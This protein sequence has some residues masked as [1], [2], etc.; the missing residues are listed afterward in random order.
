[1]SRRK[2]PPRRA[3][4]PESSNVITVLSDVAPDGRT[5]IVTVHLDGNTARTL[6]RDQGYA[7]ASTVLAAAT[8]AE[9]DAAVFRQLTRTV[10]LP[11]HLAASFLAG[12]RAD[13]PELDAD[14][15]APM[16]IEP[17]VA[18]HGE[19]FLAVFINDTQVGQWTCADARSHATGILEVVTAVDL[20]AAYFRYMVSAMGTDATEARN[21]VSDLARHI[22]KAS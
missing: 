16:R 22:P 17:G 11:Q 12:L 19:P 13:R 5:Y 7:W 21:I 8:R 1:M 2:K 9:H 4:R 14:T 20:D 3:V 6:D 18:V 10:G 15:T